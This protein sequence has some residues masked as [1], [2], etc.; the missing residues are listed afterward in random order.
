QWC[1]HAGVAYRPRGGERRFDDYDLVLAAAEEGLGVAI[2]RW[3][4][5]AT[6]LNSARLVKIGGPEF[7]GVKAHYIVTRSLENRPLIRELAAALVRMVAPRQ[8][9]AV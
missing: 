2:A 8:H 5:A 6:A 9:T 7:S 4:L 3:P 1:K